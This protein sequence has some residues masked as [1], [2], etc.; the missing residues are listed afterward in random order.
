MSSEIMKS[1][2]SW[3]WFAAILLVAV[4]NYVV[5]PVYASTGEDPW[6][7]AAIAAFLTI[8]II[9]LL[10]QEARRQGE[11]DAHVSM[12]ALGLRPLVNSLVKRIPDQPSPKPQPAQTIQCPDCKGTGWKVPQSP[13]STCRGTGIPLLARD[14][15]YVEGD[16]EPKCSACKG[17]KMVGGEKCPTC[18]GTGRMTPKVPLK[19]D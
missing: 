4:S 16:P 10:L 9:L 18:G 19:S 8:I 3:A 17:K 15:Y 6:T 5:V 11:T 7:D 14:Q 2:R 13:C 1:R 12:L